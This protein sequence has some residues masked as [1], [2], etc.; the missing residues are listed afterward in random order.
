MDLKSSLKRAANLAEEEGEPFVVGL[1]D[2]HWRVVRL[3][4]PASD[5]LRPAFI[6]D[7]DGLRYPE[8]HERVRHLIA[9]GE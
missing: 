2:R 5:L 9:Q 4:D 6:V 3:D 1:E 7:A 8:D